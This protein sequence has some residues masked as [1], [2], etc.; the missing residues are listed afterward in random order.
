VNPKANGPDNQSK[1]GSNGEASGDLKG[2]RPADKVFEEL[3]NQLTDRLSSS[4]TRAVTQAVES[5]TKVQPRWLSIESA[6]AYIDKTYSGMRYT[7]GKHPKDLPVV[8]VGEKPR[9]DIKD[10]D[11]F[12]MN[13]KRQR[14]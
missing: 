14:S 13:R 11:R 1:S 8:M 5:A 9:I 3:L 12:M 2:S 6:G 7:I 10:I 4:L